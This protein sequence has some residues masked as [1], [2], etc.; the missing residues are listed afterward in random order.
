MGFGFK[1]GLNKGAKRQRLLLRKEKMDGN[2]LDSEIN[3]NIPF[4]TLLTSVAHDNVGGTMDIWAIR[5]VND[6]ELSSDD[7]EEIQQARKF[8]NGFNEEDMLFNQE[9]LQLSQNM[10]VQDQM[11]ACDNTRSD[12]CESQEHGHYNNI[13]FVTQVSSTSGVNG[14]DR[15][16]N[17]L[18]L[19]FKDFDSG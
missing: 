16:S 4:L 5:D 8:I 17:F 10:L 9:L 19:A 6:N 7:E 14:P 12:A 18:L 11:Q 2:P 13:Y 15:T 3:A 1:I